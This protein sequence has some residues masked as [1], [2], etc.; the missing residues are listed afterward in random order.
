M[1][2]DKKCSYCGGFGH[3]IL[4]CDQTKIIVKNSK[5]K[6]FDPWRDLEYYEH[7]EAQDAIKRNPDGMTL[8]QVGEVIGVTRERIRQIEV[9]ALRKLT[10]GEDTGDLIEV[11]GIVFAVA[12]CEDC[13][14]PYPRRGRSRYC[15]DCFAARIDEMNSNELYH[16]KGKMASEGKRSPFKRIESAIVNLFSVFDD[17]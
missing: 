10:T 7:L 6:K 11:D 13:G 16:T 5:S 1:S 14:E 2:S 15:P 8:E 3:S 17:D 12:Y 4:N 9:V